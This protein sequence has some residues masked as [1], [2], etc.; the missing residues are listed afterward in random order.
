MCIHF[1]LPIEPVLLES[2]F[3]YCDVDGDG[4]INYDEFSNFLNWKDKMPS[5]E[6]KSTITGVQKDETAEGEAKVTM[7][8]SRF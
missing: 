1:N 7:H 2:M 8:V 4:Q 3:S 6:L 5:R